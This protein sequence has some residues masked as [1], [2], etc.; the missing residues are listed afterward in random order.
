MATKRRRPGSNL[1]HS[2]I[3][4]F[5]YIH[6]LR[7][8]Q[9]LSDARFEQWGIN[10]DHIFSHSAQL[11]SFLRLVEH[12]DHWLNG[13]VFPLSASKIR[14][15]SAER[16]RKV[17]SVFQGQQASRASSR[18]HFLIYTISRSYQSK[19]SP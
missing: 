15:F 12:V 14:E 19:H 1:A 7:Q 10:P 13:S 3:G 9:I 17:A 5:V 11:N 8:R 18:F 4:K 6:Y 16:L 2:M